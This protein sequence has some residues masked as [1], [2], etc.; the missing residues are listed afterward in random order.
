MG[1]LY[2]GRTCII[3]V[4]TSVYPIIQ[5]DVYCLTIFNK[6]V[7]SFTAPQHPQKPTMKMKQPTPIVVPVTM[8]MVSSANKSV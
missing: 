8:R 4:E 1:F 6:Q 7:P 3:F 5:P 2:S